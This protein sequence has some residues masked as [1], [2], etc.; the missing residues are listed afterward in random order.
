MVSAIRQKGGS[1]FKLPVQQS[2]ADLRVNIFRDIPSVF[3]DSYLSTR[4][5]ADE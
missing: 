2:L 4:S 3:G 5:R 1:L